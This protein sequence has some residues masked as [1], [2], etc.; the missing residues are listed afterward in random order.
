MN[1]KKKVAYFRNKN[2]IRDIDPDALWQLIGPWMALVD[3]DQDI[4]VDYETCKDDF[5]PVDL[6][7][8]ITESPE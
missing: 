3:D 5:Y 4:R 8:E 6:P 2:A 7:E 1:S